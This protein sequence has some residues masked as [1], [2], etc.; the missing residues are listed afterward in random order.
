MNLLIV[1]VLTLVFLAEVV[2]LA[3]GADVTVSQRSKPGG[4]AIT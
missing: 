1:A 3:K 4:T 2:W